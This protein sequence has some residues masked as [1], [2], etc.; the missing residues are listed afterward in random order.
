MK[1][2]THPI[3]F[4]TFIRQKDGTSY[5]KNWIYFRSLLVLEVDQKIWDAFN[6][7]SKNDTQRVLNDSA[8]DK[9]SISFSDSFTTNQQNIKK[10]KFN[11]WINN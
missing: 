6:F 3:L 7:K 8:I 2:N 11:F 10:S 9:K 4:N 1:K 5:T